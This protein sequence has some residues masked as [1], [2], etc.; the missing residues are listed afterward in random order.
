MILKIP[1]FSFPIS[2]HDVIRH[3]KNIKKEFFKY[4]FKKNLKGFLNNYN[5]WD[6][7]S[8]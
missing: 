8:S 7:K 2:N 6:L 5:F 3:V 1:F 4:F